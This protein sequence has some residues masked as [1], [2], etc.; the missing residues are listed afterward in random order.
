MLTFLFVIVFSLPLVVMGQSEATIDVLDLRGPMSDYTTDFVVGR[1]AAAES[2]GVVLVILQIDSPGTLTDA[3]EM[4]DAVVASAV[5]VVAWVGDA[6]AVAYGSAY[7]LAEATDLLV[8]APG[9]S[10]GYGPELTAIG[11][12]VN[13]DVQVVD[14]DGQFETSPALGELLV[15]LD[16]VTLDAAGGPVTLNTAETFTSEDG[17]ERTRVVPQVRFSEPNLLART[18]SLPLRPEAVFFF[19]TVGLAFVAFEMYAVGPGVAA[20]TAAAPLFLAGYGLTVLPI[21]WGLWLVLFSMWLLTADFQRGGFGILS[22][23]ATGLL[24][25]GGMF[26]TDTRPEMPPPFLA[27]LTISLGI[28]MFYMFA[29]STVARSR[30]TSSTIGRE[31]LVGETGTAITAP[32]FGELVVEVGTAQWRASAHRESVIPVGGEI[33][34]DGVQGLYL[35][36]RSVDDPS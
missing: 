35:E 19:L 5:P 4:I 8:V 2:E 30:F 3:S 34:V 25:V 7:A 18:M 10:L 31:Y 17:E 23:I 22:Y 33:V 24:F 36:V 15:S 16:G 27:T 29:M 13:R 14:T 20:A 1:L 26:I 9:S 6:P 12:T 11:S 32:E 28:G 21:G